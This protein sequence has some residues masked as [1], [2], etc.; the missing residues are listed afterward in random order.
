MFSEY[1]EILA[2]SASGSLVALRWPCGALCN[3]CQIV[4]FF[5]F[6]IP[7]ARERHGFPEGL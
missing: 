4:D 2:G 5:D 7:M 3:V 1:W 6:P